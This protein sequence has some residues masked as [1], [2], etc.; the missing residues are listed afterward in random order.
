ME[1][2]RGCYKSLACFTIHAGPVLKK[3]SLMSKILR[4]MFGP[5]STLVYSALKI[6]SFLT[7]L[8]LLM[9][10]TVFYFDISVDYNNMVVESDISKCILTA[11]LPCTRLTYISRA[12]NFP[13]FSSE[14]FSQALSVAVPLTAVIAALSLCVEL[15]NSLLE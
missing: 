1:T 14:G 5:G 15:G 11:T 4:A 10:L 9:A 6:L 7:I 13:E 8:G 12:L 2:E 3:P